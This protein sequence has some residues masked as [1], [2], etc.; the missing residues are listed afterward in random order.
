MSCFF[1]RISRAKEY[2]KVD[3]DVLKDWPL[4]LIHEVLVSYNTSPHSALGG[5][6]PFT[7]ARGYT[8]FPTNPTSIDET[9]DFLWD[10]SETPE[11]VYSIGAQKMVF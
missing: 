10:L 2:K 9:S 6:V 3:P 7:L 4:W 5:I 1:L 8:Y 11:P